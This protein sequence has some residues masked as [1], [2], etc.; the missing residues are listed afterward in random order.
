MA[1]FPQTAMRSGGRLVALTMLAACGLW[2]AVQSLPPAGVRSA[3][4]QREIPP[5]WD[6]VVEIPDLGRGL[7]HPTGKHGRSAVAGGLDPRHALIAN[8]DVVL[9]QRCPQAPHE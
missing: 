8:L 4:A 3:Q 7:A 9:L 6:F 2:A 1:I 5:S